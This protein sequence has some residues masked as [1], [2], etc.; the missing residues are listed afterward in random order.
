MVQQAQHV[1]ILNLVRAIKDTY[2][3]VVSAGELKSYP[4]Y[5]RRYT[6]ANE[7]GNFGTLILP[8]MIR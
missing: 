3:F 7:F 1:K 8:M 5:H 6:D 2:W 4:D